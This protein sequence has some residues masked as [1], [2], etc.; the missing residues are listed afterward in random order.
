MTILSDGAFAGTSPNERGNSPRDWA[1]SELVPN[2]KWKYH[3]VIPWEM[4]R[5]TWQALLMCQRWKELTNYVNAIGADGSLVK[6]LQNKTMTFEDRDD[7]FAR[8]SWPAWNIVE[9]PADRD[10]EGGT[11]LDI[12]RHGLTSNQ[13]K[14]MDHI[15]ELHEAMNKFLE[16]FDRKAMMK[17]RSSNS[18]A[19]A[20]KYR[21][22]AGAPEASLNSIDPLT[23]ALKNMTSYKNSLFIPYCEGMWTITVEGRVNAKIVAWCRTPRFKKYD[24]MLPQPPSHSV[25]QTGLTKC[26]K[27][28]RKF[29]AK[30]AEQG[31][32]PGLRVCPGCGSH[33]FVE[34]S[35]FHAQ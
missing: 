5:D 25:P 27:C 8:L 3:H 34:R 30:K 22:Q 33:V 11:D 15:Y 26:G 17:G 28:L 23:A 6:R 2:I 21:P 16:P 32:G 35:I 9:G 12:F 24:G 10:D 18:G 1:R 20:S 29:N 19:Q 4:Q 13:V 31:A 7:L 14:R